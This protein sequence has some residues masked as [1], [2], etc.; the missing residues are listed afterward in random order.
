MSIIVRTKKHSVGTSGRC[1]CSSGTLVEH[2]FL[3]F[4]NFMLVKDPARP[5]T[6]GPP[7]AEITVYSY[8]IVGT[9][10]MFL[11]IFP[12]IDQSTN[13]SLNSSNSAHVSWPSTDQSPSGK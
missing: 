2:F 9:N 5:N 10:N 11:P 6:C 4:N 1:I 8:R 7:F 13:V 3:D 12:I